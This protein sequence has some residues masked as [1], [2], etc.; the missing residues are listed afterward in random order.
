MGTGNLIRN[1]LYSL[2]N[3]VQNSMLA[4]PKDLMV[5]VLQDSFSKDSYWHFVRDGFGFPKT[6]NLTDVPIEAGLRDDVTSRIFI[7]Q[8]FRYDMKFYPAIIVRGGSFRSVPISMSRNDEM[9]QY[10]ATKVVDGY[11]NEKIFSIP[12]H[13]ITTGAYEGSITID[14]IAGDLNARDE[15]VDII[16][17]LLT[18]VCFKTF[19]NAGVLIKPVSVGNPSETEDLKDRLYKQS[20]TCEIRCEW[21]RH[22]PIDSILDAIAFCVEFSDLSNPNQPAAANLQINTMVELLDAIQSI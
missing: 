18:E 16:F 6:P 1:D 15:L 7:G 21:R 10:R 3:I 5:E 13:F 19:L 11:G 2:N 22:V 4:Y 14:V 12:S 9:V 8:A 20:I 17:I